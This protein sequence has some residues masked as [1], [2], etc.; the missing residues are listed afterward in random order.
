MLIRKQTSNM[1]GIDVSVWQ[2][3]VDFKL[4]KKSGLAFVIL[5][6]GYGGDP[7][8]KDPRFA[9]NYANYVADNLLSEAVRT[10]Y[11]FRIAQWNSQCTYKGQYGLWQNSSKGMAPG[12]NG[13][14]DRD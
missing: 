14:V 3:R 11:A 7:S 6:A 1:R 2:G 4:V 5:R 12:I 10:R 13:P 8:H 9:E